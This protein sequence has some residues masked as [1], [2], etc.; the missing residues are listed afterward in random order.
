[1]TGPLHFDLVAETYER[2]RPPYPEALWAR[3][4]ELGVLRPGVRVVE[5]GAGT[6]QAAE[7]LI[8]EGAEVVAVEPGAALAARL[9]LR[10]PDAQVVEARAEDAEL[11]EGRFDLAV[12]ATSVHWL[13]L[14]VVLPALRRAVVRGG[15]FAVWRHTF[16]DPRVRTPF[17]ERI[18]AIVA[19]RASEPTWSQQG[20]H[21]N[22]GWARRLSASGEFEAVH[23]DE[24]RW[25]IDLDADQVVDLFRTFSAWTADEAAAAGRAAR[26]LD[27]TVTEHYL[28]PLILLRRCG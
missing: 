9:R 1:M 12:A 15:H 13:D 16:G 2:A 28:T 26:D 20:E 14:A 25:S 27:G 23:L 8:E 19:L 22:H 17:R 11:G 3:L 10:C 21:D 4:R 6:G 5:L 7:R 24:F 18:E